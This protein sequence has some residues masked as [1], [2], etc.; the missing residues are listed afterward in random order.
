MEDGR[1]GNR[2]SA[3]PSLVSGSSKLVIMDADSS[4]VILGSPIFSKRDPR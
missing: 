4:G 3:A 2:W 1:G